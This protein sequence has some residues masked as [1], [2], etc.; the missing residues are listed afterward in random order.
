MSRHLAK[1][2]SITPVRNDPW[3]LT[4]TP[5]ARQKG[6]YG[7]IFYKEILDPNR[8]NQRP[9]FTPLKVSTS[10]EILWSAS[11]RVHF[12]LEL[13]RD[14]ILEP[15]CIP[16]LRYSAMAASR[17]KFELIRGL[18][19]PSSTLSLCTCAIDQWSICIAICFLRRAVEYTFL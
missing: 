7:P 15:R 19:T 14:L 13:N 4:R 16:F 11:A 9:N 18:F 2:P 10:A 3:E 17:K 8:M 6:T 1:G 5:L 12:L